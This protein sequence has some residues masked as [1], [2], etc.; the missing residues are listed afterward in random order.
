MRFF[1]VP[2]GG[3]WLIEPEPVAD[4]RGSFARIWCAEEFR[5]HGLSPRLAQCSVSVNTRRGTLR[6]M[7]YQEEPYPE[8][9]LVRCCAGA[10]YEVIVDLRPT[11]PSRGKWF[12]V[13]LTV[14]NRKMLYVPEGVAHG[15]QTLADGTEVL[16]QIS[17]AY[18][19]ELARGVRWNDPSF[20]IEWPI[21]D[22]ILSARDAA[23]P[24][25]RS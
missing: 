3:A 14:A 16:Y 1:G 6:G 8:A 2:L 18:R 23:F 9:K 20:G 22:P 15:F 5:S 10:I 19:P 25:Y 21:P 12:A 7:H 17:E 11:S 13:E 4:E 24:D